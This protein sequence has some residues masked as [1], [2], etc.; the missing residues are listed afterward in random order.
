MNE[1]EKCQQV[2]VKCSENRM[3]GLL[4]ADDIIVGLA[5]AGPALKSL[6]NVAYNYSKCWSFKANVKSAVVNFSKPWND[7]GKWVWGCESLLMSDSYCYLWT[8]FS[9]FMWQNILNL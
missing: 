2:G 5:G 1:I 4:F 3:S 6:I 7:S 8:E 9:I